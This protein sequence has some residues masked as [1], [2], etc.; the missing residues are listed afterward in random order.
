MADELDARQPPLHGGPLSPA[1]ATM[2]NALPGQSR[3]VDVQFD[4]SGVGREIG[5]VNAATATHAPAIDQALRFCGLSTAD[6]EA[7]MAALVAA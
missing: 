1:M 6:R 3:V 5:S 4:R 7:F 2:L